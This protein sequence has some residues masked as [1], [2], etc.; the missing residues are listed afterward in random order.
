MAFLH[1]TA[2]AVTKITASS[3]PDDVYRDIVVDARPAY[4]RPKMYAEPK[5]FTDVTQFLLTG[6]VNAIVADTV[7][8]F[9]DADLYNVWVPVILAARPEIVYL[10][11][12]G[13]KR[14]LRL[15]PIKCRI[16]TGVLKLL[17]GVPDEG[18]RLVANTD[19]ITFD[20][21]TT[22]LLYDVK[23]GKSTIN[24]VEVDFADM[25]FTFEAPFTDTTVDL[26]TV[27][28]VYP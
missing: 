6:H 14:I 4:I 11:N 8:T 19:T 20:G 17:G 13:T 28:R 26:A 5:D 9:T 18:V 24:G 27:P 25:N 23:F 15:R 22:A 7:D 12:T 21:D 2:T 1:K 16:D 10:K 3:V